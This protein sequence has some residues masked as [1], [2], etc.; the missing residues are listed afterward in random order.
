MQLRDPQPDLTG[1]RLE[2]AFLV[3]GPRIPAI[4]RRSYRCAPQNLVR[5][6]VQQRVQRLLDAR[7]HHLIDIPLLF[8][9]RITPVRGA[10]LSSSMVASLQVSL[11]GN[12]VTTIL[13]DRGHCTQT[14]RKKRYLN[15]RF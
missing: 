5:F 15:R 9:N 1:L 8:V 2:L 4:R 14:V 11:M 6:R 13:P 7:P 10:E 3:P 12:V